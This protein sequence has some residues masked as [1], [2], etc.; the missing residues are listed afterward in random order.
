MVAGQNGQVRTSPGDRE[1]QLLAAVRSVHADLRLPALSHSVVN[2][3]MTLTG[4]DTAALYVAEDAGARCVAAHDTHQHDVDGLACP[5]L[6][7]HSLPLQQLRTTLQ[8]V[9]VE[10]TE[11]DP[12]W[13]TVARS[14]PFAQRIRCWLAVPLHVGE[15]FLGFVDCGFEQR[16][17]AEGA[18]H[19]LCEFAGDAAQSLRH[20]LLL[21]EQVTQADQSRLRQELRATLTGAEDA[22]LNLD[23]AVAIIDQAFM[24]SCCILRAQPVG[25]D[26]ATSAWR[27]RDD[28]HL[29]RRAERLLLPLVSAAGRRRAPLVVHDLEA[30][31]GAPEEALAVRESLLT[32]GVRALLIAPLLHGE[33][34]LGALIAIQ[35]G[36]RRAW[37]P[38][39]VVL[40][41]ALAEDA[42]TAVQQARALQRGE[43]RLTMLQHELDRFRTTFEYLPLGVVIGDAPDAPRFWNRAAARLA[44]NGARAEDPEPPAFDLRR[45]DGQTLAPD[46]TPSHRAY[47]EDR[48]QH[49]MLTVRRHDGVMVPTTVSAMPL[50]DRDGR[51]G[52]VVTMLQDGTGLK[53]SEEHARREAQGRRLIEAMMQLVGEEL[54]VDDLVAQLGAQIRDLL[55]YDRLSVLT[56]GDDDARAERVATIDDV[57]QPSTAD[58][59]VDEVLARRAIAAEGPEL[60]GDAHDTHMEEGDPLRQSGV[61]AWLTLP[62]EIGDRR[63]GALCLMSRRPSVFH[64]DDVTLAADLA[65][66]VGIAVRREVAIKEARESAMRDERERL[67]REIHDTLAQTITT[68]V[69]QLDLVATREPDDSPQKARIEQARIMAREALAETRRAVWN[70]RPQAVSLQEPRT[71]LQDE[72]AL[73]ERRMHVKPEVIAS[74]EERQVAPEVGAVLQRLLHVALENTWAHSEAEHVRILLDYGLQSLTLLVEDDGRGFDPDIIDLSGEGRVGLAGVAERVRSIGGTLRVES[75]A[76]QGTRVQAELPYAPLPAVRPS[77]VAVSDVP[78]PARPVISTAE[79]VIRVLLIDD[80]AMVREG[81]ERMMQDQPDLQVVGAGANGTEGLRLIADLQPDVVLCDLQLPDMSGVEVI[82]KVRTHFPEIRCL[83]VTTYDDDESIYEGFKA[84][85][86]GYVLKDVS[87]TELANAVRAAARGESLLQPIVARK[88]VEGFGELARQGGI[89]ETLTEREIEVLRALASGARNKEIAFSLGLSESTIKTHLASIFGKLSVTTRTEAVAKGRDLGLISL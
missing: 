70:M 30:P 15:R 60:M 18:Q 89:V 42:A 79:A 14:R 12:R 81:L 31:E 35:V 1:A 53:R 16:A 82:A 13:A 21:D 43:R 41:R 48:T 38:G 65:R 27:Q 33:E 8:P 54:G 74:G 22:R 25:A 2:A 50:H 26:A 80:H 40:A 87:A 84:G 9:I 59:V 75:A 44:T 66:G 77:P 39:D 85:A 67:A 32:L 49:Q 76:S 51:P 28:V 86:K 29:D 73:F 19:L 57:E 78:S 56:L 72:V 6:S 4:A 52:A 47:V 23:A 71:V 69:M 58:P 11:R 68:M 37:Q 10:D 5:P 88:L 24:A 45:Q 36:E 55:P 20:A 63:Y 64:E 46:E 3:V 34:Q 17:R 83:V 62:L 61:R 7:R